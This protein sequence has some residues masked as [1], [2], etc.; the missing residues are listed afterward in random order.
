MYSL[1]KNRNIDY[2]VSPQS[3]SDFNKNILNAIHKKFG[4]SIG[5]KVI[6]GL[7]QKDVRGIYV[8]ENA[9]IQ[10]ARENGITDTNEIKNF[11]DTIKKR[12]DRFHRDEERRSL[13]QQKKIL[14][15]EVAEML[16]NRK[17]GRLP[18]TITDK[19]EKI[20]NI[21]V[22]QNAL[23]KNDEG[24]FDKGRDSAINKDGS[25]KQWQIK[26]LDDNTRK[27]ISG[28][29]S[30][31]EPYQQDRWQDKFKN[32]SVLIFDDN[33]SSGASLDNACLTLKKSGVNDIIA[34]T[35]GTIPQSVYG[36]DRY[37]NVK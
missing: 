25:V 26:S 17:Q 29:F 5:I 14:E 19:Q 28:I 8:D 24:Q 16:S 7:L 12:V 13:L 6:P 3:S 30:F 23:R 11:V 35:L 31:A 34:I 33:Y 9:A 1:I 18:K 21:D 37:K 36:T 15:Q 32:K 2:L 10:T 4:N 22:A 27:S 20:K